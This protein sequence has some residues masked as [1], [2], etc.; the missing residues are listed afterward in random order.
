VPF[1]SLTG[2]PDRAPGRHTSGATG[3][4]GRTWSDV[5]FRGLSLEPGLVLSAPRP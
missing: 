5:A 3:R 2:T 4:S 1:Q